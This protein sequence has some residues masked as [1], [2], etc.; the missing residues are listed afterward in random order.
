[1]DLPKFLSL[2]GQSLVFNQPDSTFVFYVPENYFNNSVKVPIAEIFG[3][4]V[5][6]I[7]VCNWAIIDKNGKRS[8]IM[9]FQFPTMMLCKPFEIESVKNLQLDSTDP[10]D[11]KLLKFHKGDEVVSQI[12]VPQLIDNVEMF[13]K[14]F[15]LTAKIPTTIPY[16][17]LWSLFL[18]SAS[19]NG[20]SYGLNI[21]LIC[22]LIASICRDKNDISKPFKATSMSDMNAYK[23]IDIRMVPK[24]ISPYTA[25]TSENWDEALRAAILLKDKENIPTSPTEK[26]VT[27]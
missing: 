20:F 24:F 3:E 23:P 10:S 5:S 4:Y 25:I 27:M 16:D 8:K 21:Q 6:M 22:I 1:M 9:P 7:G 26:V 11:Y 17:K 15:V 18:E 13:F 14:M 12:R 2:E 19:L